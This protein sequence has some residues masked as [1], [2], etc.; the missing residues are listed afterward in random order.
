MSE[1]NALLKKSALILTNII[2]FIALGLISY[3]A[4]IALSRKEKGS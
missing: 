1:I 3:Y 2:S 4:R